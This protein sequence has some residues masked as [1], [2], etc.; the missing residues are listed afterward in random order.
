MSLNCLL[1]NINE[2]K[3]D[4]HDASRKIL[5]DGGGVELSTIKPFISDK[6]QVEYGLN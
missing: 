4:E 5:E 1:I 3:K 6:T 2:N